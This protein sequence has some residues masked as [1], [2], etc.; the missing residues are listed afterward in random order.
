[1]IIGGFDSNFAVW[2]DGL[3]WR[4]SCKVAFTSNKVYFP[5]S[6]PRIG[7]LCVLQED[8]WPGGAL[9][10]HSVV[11]LCSIKWGWIQVLIRKLQDVNT[12]GTSNPLWVSGSPPGGFLGKEGCPGGTG[13]SEATPGALSHPKCLW[14]L[15]GPSCPNSMENHLEALGIVRE[16]DLPDSPR[17][18]WWASTEFLPLALSLELW[19]AGPGG[20]VGPGVPLVSLVWGHSGVLRCDSHP[21]CVTTVGLLA[22]LVEFCWSLECNYCSFVRGEMRDFHPLALRVQIPIFEQFVWT[23]WRCFI[24]VKQNFVPWPLVLFVFWGFGI[25]FFWNSCHQHTINV[26][27]FLTALCSSPESLPLPRLE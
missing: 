25:W 3:F 11:T 4:N 10:G 7:I 9:W 2:L 6:L 21:S 5:W 19:V 8:Q 13:S 23:E 17:K 15:P 22:F 24:N 14:E 27:D 12:S 26:F 18:I 1:M 20:G 16:T